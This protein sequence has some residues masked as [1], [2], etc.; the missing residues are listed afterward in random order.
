M[1][2]RP[3]RS[4]GKPG[5][6]RLAFRG[7]YCDRHRKERQAQADQY[8]GTAASRGYDRRWRKARKRYLEQHPLCVMC[9]AE[10]R[11]TEAT[12]VDH[13]IPH[14]GDKHLFWSVENWQPLCK[15][16]H[17]QKTAAEDGGFGRE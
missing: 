6:S 9:K 4:C 2:I 14:K 3:G 7:G 11:T 5:C 1:P 15:K 12:V 17:D 8:R 16:H 13:K 10:G